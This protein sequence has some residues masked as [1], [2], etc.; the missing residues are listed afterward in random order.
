MD[1]RVVILA[2]PLRS[3]K[4]TALSRWAGDLDAAGFLTPE[5]ARGRRIVRLDEE[6]DLPFEAGPAQG[7]AQVVGR[8]RI[9]DSAFEAGARWLREGL[10]RKASWLILDE[11][12]P[13]EM[14]GGGFHA[15]FREVLET[16]A[17]DGESTRLLVVMRDSV[18]DEAAARYG[19]EFAP[20]IGK[21][22]LDALHRKDGP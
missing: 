13:L 1:E 8:F 10:R 7:P 2:G 18:A 11:I 20:R 16:L 3:G 21:E 17:R 19:L 5:G 15:I 4:T 6:A 9:L 22:R 14:A 12:G